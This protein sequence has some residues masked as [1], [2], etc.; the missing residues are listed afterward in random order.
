MRLLLHCFHVQ[1][2][3]RLLHGSAAY[4]S[5]L[6]CIRFISILR[7]SV[8]LFS[9]LL[10]HST[11]PYSSLVFSARS[12]FPPYYPTLLYSALLLVHQ[13]H[14]C[15]LFAETLSTRHHDERLSVI[16]SVCFGI[17]LMRLLLCTLI[18]A[19]AIVAMLQ[20]K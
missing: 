10:L 2:L 5:V 13:V 15:Y 12:S 6:F 3:I 4:F 20:R 18:S 7:F 8:P 19:A 11:I 1:H 16:I 17:S 9:L 14:L